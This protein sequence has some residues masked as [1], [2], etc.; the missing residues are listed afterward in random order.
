MSEQ[1]P[2]RPV[3]SARCRDGHPVRPSP[4]VHPVLGMV[5]AQSATWF[6]AIVLALVV[7][8]LWWLL[9]AWHTAVLVVLAG[10]VLVV[11]LV[12]LALGHR[13]GCLVRRTVRWFLGPVGALVDPFDLD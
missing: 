4:G 11:L 9:P 7:G 1:R 3:P 6:G 13:G 10:W 2:T 12:Q 5:P 8:L